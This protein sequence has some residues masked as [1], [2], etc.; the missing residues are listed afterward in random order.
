MRP[1]IL[2]VIYIAAVHVFTIICLLGFDLPAPCCAVAILVIL[3]SLARSIRQWLCQAP[4][5]I[6]FESVYSCWS[7]LVDAPPWQ[8]HESINVAYL[9]DTLVWITLASPGSVKRVAIIGVD[10]MENERF[11]QLRRC[12]LCPDMFDR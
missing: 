4:Y 6:K 8:R 12:I 2:V 5:F 9:N 3:A 10:S 1:S 7:V 11:R